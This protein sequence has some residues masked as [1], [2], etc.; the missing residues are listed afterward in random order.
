[1]NTAHFKTKLEE[2]LKTLNREIGENAHVSGQEDAAATESDELADKIEDLEEGKGENA[3]L[4]A[5]KEEVEAALKRVEDGTYGTCTVGGEA[6]EEERL[7]AD[8]AA[9]TCTAHLEA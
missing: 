6:I 2:E 8:P 1:M 4:R 5:R 7:E 3:A 9:Q